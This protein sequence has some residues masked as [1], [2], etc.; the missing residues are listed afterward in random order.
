MR[1]ALVTEAGTGLGTA[2]ARRLD[3][4]GYGLAL[5]RRRREP[6]ERVA[7]ELERALVVPGDVADPRLADELVAVARAELGG[8]D[9]L[10]LNAGIGDAARVGEHPLRRP[11]EP[12]EVAAVVAFLLS[13]EAS[14]VTGAAVPVDG[15]TLVVDR[16]TT[17]WVGA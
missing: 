11:A 10:V 1:V 12:D 2:V 4:D 16:S 9:A 8:V 13:D 15:G 5:A 7:A 3:R 6:L 17:A 14:S